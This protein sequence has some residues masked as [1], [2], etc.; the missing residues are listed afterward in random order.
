MDAATAYEQRD[1]ALLLD[2]RQPGEWAVGRIEQ[3]VLLPMGE[4]AARQDELPTDKQIIVV[5]RSGNRSAMVTRALQQAGYDA[6][7][8]DGGMQVWAREG[9]PVVADG[10][11]PG[12]V[13]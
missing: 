12:A 1:A 8:L 11:A 4:L 9:F 7:N 6:A 10:G 13:A 5:C 3:A 2:V